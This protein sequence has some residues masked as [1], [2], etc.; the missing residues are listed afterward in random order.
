MP[1]RIYIPGGR[2]KHIKQLQS[3][4][5]TAPWDCGPST[6]LVG[7][8]SNSRNE[9]RP[10]PYWHQKWIRCIRQPM[11]HYIGYPAINTINVEQSIES[12]LIR[13]MQRNRG[14][15]PAEV[16]W[17]V[18]T[19]KECA[20]KLKA[21]HALFVGIDY[22]RLNRLMPRLSGSR[23]YRKGHAIGLRGFKWDGR[24]VWTLLYDP[25]HDG[26]RPGIP[27]GIQTVRLR[28]YLR[29]AETWGYPQPGPGHARVAIIR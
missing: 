6:I 11:T 16:N 15:R 17:Q 22:D 14:V 10:G 4:L 1:P 26:R 13:R 8:E 21:G 28:K 5:W 18:L 2:P 19:F 27:R 29:A 12:G 9:I 24:Y 23:T 7:L 25:L 20:Q 3:G